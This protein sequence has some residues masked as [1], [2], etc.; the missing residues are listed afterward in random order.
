MPRW[1]VEDA[2]F[3]VKYWAILILAILG[4]WH[5]WSAGEKYN[6]QETRQIKLVD[7]W[8]YMSGNKTSATEYW[9]GEFVD[10]KTSKHFELE[11]TPQFYYQFT[12]GNRAPIVTEHSFEI[13]RFNPDA[14]FWSQMFGAYRILTTTIVI[15]CLLRPVGRWLNRVDEYDW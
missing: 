10:L 9:K 14:Q 1:T 13:G 2:R 6:L 15:I 8:S 4:G 7:A 12:R 5:A 11:L 3:E